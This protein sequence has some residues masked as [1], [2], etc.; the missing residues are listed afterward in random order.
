MILR[1]RMLARFKAPRATDV[2]AQT[3][4]LKPNS[5]TADGVAMEWRLTKKSS[6]GLIA[7]VALIMGSTVFV[8]STRRPEERIF[9]NL[10]G[11]ILDS[12]PFAIDGVT[13]GLVR[14]TDRVELESDCDHFSDNVVLPDCSVYLSRPRVMGHTPGPPLKPLFDDGTCDG[15]EG[16]R[17]LPGAPDPSRPWD[18][19]HR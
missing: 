6:W 2:A 3:R 15:S 13:Y 1:V 8:A 7:V 5:S 9:C 16:G 18:Y 17:L 19:D 4:K 12:K 11:R 14:L 10:H